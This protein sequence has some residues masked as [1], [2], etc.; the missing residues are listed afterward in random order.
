MGVREAVS[1]VLAVAW[2]DLL[3]E[4]RTKAGFNGVVFMSATTLLMFGFAL[5]PD[6]AAIRAAAVGMLW[7]T[8]LL[9]GA[10][11]FNRSYELEAEAGAFDALLMYPGGRWAIFAGK[12]LANLAFVLL[13]EAI[14]VPLAAVLYDLPVLAPLPGL[15]TVLLLGTVGFVT[16]GTYYAAMA[17]RV[18]AREVLLPLLLFPMLVPLLVAAVGATKAVLVGDPMGHGAGWIKL[19]AAFDIIFL[20]GTFM[21]FEYV[22]GE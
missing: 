14:T 2:K 10:L 22:V 11:A 3:T 7:L 21:T 8:V 19:I 4:R 15:I 12:L 17:S 9:S 5:G 18:R 6:P 13:V 16:L 1:R 20:V